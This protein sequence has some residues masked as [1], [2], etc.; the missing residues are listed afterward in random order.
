MRRQWIS[1]AAVALALGAACGAPAATPDEPA[2]EGDLE[3]WA[4]VLDAAYHRGGLDYARLAADRAELDAAFPP[5]RRKRA[6]A[7]R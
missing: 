5:P 3:A 7:M 6:L 1:G 2:G 4:A